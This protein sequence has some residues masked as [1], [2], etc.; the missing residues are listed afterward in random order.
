VSNLSQAGARTRRG[1]TVDVVTSNARSLA[2]VAIASDDALIAVFDAKLAYNFWRPI[3]AIR[4]GDLDGNDATERDCGWL[5]LLDTPMHP[6]YPCA[7]CIVAA[8]VGTIL[9]AEIDKGARCRLPPRRRSW[10][11]SFTSGCAARP[12]RAVRHQAPPRRAQ[13]SAKTPA[14]CRP[15]AAGRPGSRDSPP[16]R[17]WRSP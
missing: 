5:P 7:H 10:M 16:T 9:E 1:H 4:N 14:R 2:V 11:P 13:G 12:K 6:E 3:S 15:P 8:T 17:P